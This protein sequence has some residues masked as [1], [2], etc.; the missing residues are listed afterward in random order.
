MPFWPVYCSP[1]SHLI[2][3]IFFP[4]PLRNQ[5]LSVEYLLPLLPNMIRTFKVENYTGSPAQI[6]QG[7]YSFSMSTDSTTLRITNPGNPAYD[8]EKL[9]VRYV[10]VHK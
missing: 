6:E 2:H 1:E 8:Y 4:H 5:A 10:R 9:E 3:P 7:S